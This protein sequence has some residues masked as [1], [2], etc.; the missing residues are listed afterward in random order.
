MSDENEI[1][2]NT[3]RFSGG[4]TESTNHGWFEHNTHGDN[5]GGELFFDGK[6][7]ID[8]DGVFALPAEIIT[9]LEELGFNMAYAKDEEA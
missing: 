9:K 1:K 5:F 3:A 7:L 4:I 2:F 6:K 8:Y